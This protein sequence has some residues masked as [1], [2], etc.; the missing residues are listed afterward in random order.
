MSKAWAIITHTWSVSFADRKQRK[1]ELVTPC[2]NSKTF[3]TGPQW[4]RPKI[5]S[6][7]RYEVS[8]L[9]TVRWN[10]SLNEVWCPIRSQS[11]DLLGSPYIMKW[12]I[13]A[14]DSCWPTCLGVY[15]IKIRGFPRNVWSTQMASL[16]DL[17]IN[18]R[19]TVRNCWGRLVARRP[20]QLKF[21]NFK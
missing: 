6:N 7:T 12:D 15:Y 2:L 1:I 13:V 18:W 9:I 8:N 10:I 16:N 21:T 3:L 20:W 19:D 4:Y 11:A 14:Y 17:F 5:R